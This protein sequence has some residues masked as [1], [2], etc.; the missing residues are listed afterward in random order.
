[1]ERANEEDDGS[2]T[3]GWP[4]VSPSLQ[5]T[6]CFTPVANNHAAEPG[7]GL[8]AQNLSKVPDNHLWPRLGSLCIR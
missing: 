6:A 4:G 2:L 1:M 5:M 8:M 7:L 3:A